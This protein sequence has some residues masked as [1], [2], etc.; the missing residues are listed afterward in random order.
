[1]SVKYIILNTAHQLVVTKATSF[2]WSKT[3]DANKCSVTNLSDITIRLV[4]ID[5]ENCKSY[6]VTSCISLSYWR[7][8][9][10]DLHNR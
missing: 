4:T 1:M 10:V 2:K 5:F 9:D 7:R 3:L 6:S 8:R